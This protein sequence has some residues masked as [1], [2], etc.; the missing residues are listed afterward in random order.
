MPTNCDVG[1]MTCTFGDSFSSDA[2]APRVYRFALCFSDFSWS[3]RCICFTT[4]SGRFRIAR[5][6][7]GKEFLTNGGFVLDP[8]RNYDIL[9]NEHGDQSQISMSRLT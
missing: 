5:G 1:G 4:M 3:F 2:I 6:S 8:T 9:E 7:R